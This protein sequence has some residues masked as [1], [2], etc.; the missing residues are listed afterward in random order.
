MNTSQSIANNSI[1][2][3]NI[4]TVVRRNRSLAAAL[5][6]VVAYATLSWDPFGD[7]N[8]VHIFENGGEL[9][10]ASMIQ[11]KRFLRQQDATNEKE[12]ENDKEDRSND[13]SDSKEE[14]SADIL[15]QNHHRAIA[16]ISFGES[17]ANSTLVERA[18]LSIRRRGAF[19][20]PVMVLT[21]APE[22]RYD[23]VFDEHV[24][25]VNSKDGDLKFGYFEN[26]KHDRL[27]NIYPNMYE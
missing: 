11:S 22:K 6:F 15:Q 27:H 16:L 7:N 23:G 2:R 12:V 8:S 24:I 18:V 25:V 20:G 19:N 26:G 10:S 4:A 5:V 21:D 9:A 1:D 14:K 3:C 13:D 17:A